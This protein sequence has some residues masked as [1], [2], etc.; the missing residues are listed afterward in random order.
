MPYRAVL[1]CVGLAARE[2]LVPLRNLDSARPALENC[3]V[4][5]GNHPEQ[6][7]GANWQ[8]S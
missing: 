2:T 5:L 8:H 7:L 1:C 6:K 3:H 4:V